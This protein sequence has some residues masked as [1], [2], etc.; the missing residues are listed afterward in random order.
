MRIRQL[1]DAFGTSHPQISRGNVARQQIPRAHR[2]VAVLLCC[3]VLASSQTSFAA[4]TTP[5]SLT[6]LSFTPAVIDTTSGS[7]T[8]TVTARILDSESGV[9]PAPYLW[10]VTD[11]ANQGASGSLSRISG[12]ANDGVYRGTVTS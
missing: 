12:T 6:E 11:A 4:D 1:V 10:F 8:I 5:P 7:A 3:V 2:A 9:S